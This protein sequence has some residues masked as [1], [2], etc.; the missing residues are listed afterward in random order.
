M[1][2]T[3]TDTL[4]KIIEDLKKKEEQARLSNLQRYEQIQKIWDEIIRRYEPGG[5]F[6]A[7]ALEQL[8]AQ[9]EREV[10]AATQRLISSGLFGTQAAA[11]VGMQWERTVG[12]P[13]RLRLEDIM[14][15]RLSQAQIGK[16]QAIE[17]REDIYPDYGLM[18]QLIAQAAAAPRG[19]TR[20]VMPSKPF[21]SL[22]GRVAPP[23]EPETTP[24]YRTPEYFE[25]LEKARQAAA[26]V[27]ESMAKQKPIYGDL[28]SQDALRSQFEEWKRKRLEEIEKRYAKYRTESGEWKPV[29]SGVYGKGRVARMT[30]EAIRSGYAY[31]RSLTEGLTFEQWKK[32]TGRM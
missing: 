30:K 6:E 17:R 1:P 9:K 29:E 2:V 24:Y 28:R 13:A 7:R 20:I 16:A 25:R 22:P 26:Q 27:R 19:V 31:S 5:T 8:A 32:R 14:M 3:G 18:S 21:P 23:P 4:S 11:G 12:A 10:G 15:Q